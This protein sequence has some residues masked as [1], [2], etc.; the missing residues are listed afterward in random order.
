[1][2][3]GGRWCV[4]PAQEPP[5]NGHYRNYYVTP[6]PGCILE[7]ALK[8]FLVAFTQRRLAKGRAL[9]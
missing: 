2:A 3:G 1:M 5:L 8:N 9:A 4:S 6:D 7:S